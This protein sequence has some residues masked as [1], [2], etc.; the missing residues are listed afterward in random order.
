MLVELGLGEQLEGTVTRSH[1]RDAAVPASHDH[2]GRA[3]TSRE[4]PVESG[5]A[6]YVL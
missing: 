6:V 3:G 2:C 1:G 4:S 5:S